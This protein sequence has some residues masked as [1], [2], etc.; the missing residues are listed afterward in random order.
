MINTILL[1]S[2][3]RAASNKKIPLE[4]YKGFMSLHPFSV[5][6]KGFMSCAYALLQGGGGAPK[7]QKGTKGRCKYRKKFQT[8]PSI[9][10]DRTHLVLLVQLKAASKCRRKF[11][12][13]QQP[14]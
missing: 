9:N 5:Q 11:L 4:E 8:I 12:D 6:L 14:F 1:I 3:I 2:N 13:R 10:V 7:H